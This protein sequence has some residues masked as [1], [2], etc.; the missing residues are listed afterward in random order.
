[1]L[2]CAREILEHAGF[3][4]FGGAIAGKAAKGLQDESGIASSTI[5]QFLIDIGSGKIKLHDKAVLFLDEAG[6]IGSV[7]MTELAVL[8]D[9]AGAKLMLVGDTEQLPPVAAGAPMASLVKH[10][11]EDGVVYTM[12]QITRQKEEWMRTVVHRLQAPHH[13]AFELDAR[14]RPIERN[15]KGEILPYRDAHSAAAA[16]DSAAP[17]K[18]PLA[19]ARHKWSGGDR[20]AACPRAAAFSWRAKRHGARHG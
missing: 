4:C 14:G 5:E 13:H 2:E 12:S 11:S 6:M 15:E 10:F 18:R 20:R 1:L 9:N 7:Q 17:E 8:C 19:E 16:G 3:E